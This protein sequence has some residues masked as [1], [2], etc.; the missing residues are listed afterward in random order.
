MPVLPSPTPGSLSL[1]LI[2]QEKGRHLPLQQALVPG[3]SRIKVCPSILRAVQLP[4][5][6]LTSLSLRVLP[7][8]RY[9]KQHLLGE[10]SG[11]LG[12]IIYTLFTQPLLRLSASS[13][14]VPE[15]LRSCVVIT[16][17]LSWP[18][19]PGRTPGWGCFCHVLY[20][21][22]PAVLGQQQDSND[23]LV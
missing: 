16:C 5:R 4:P 11:E 14:G 7:C 23:G 13:C 19:Q 15:P 22:F 20:F 2:P 21:Q 9:E 18:P 17:F 8:K 1:L 12:K 6:A 10:L 3:L